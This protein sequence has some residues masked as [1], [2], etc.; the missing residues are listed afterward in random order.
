MTFA[1]KGSTLELRNDLVI[2][3]KVFAVNETYRYDAGSS[4]WR[5][6]T[7]GNAYT[8]VAPTW[9]QDEWT[10][11]GSVPKG[12]ARAKVRM[13]YT[14][15]GANAFRREYQRSENDAWTTFHSQ[16]CHRR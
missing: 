12:N 9:T 5:T 14:Y 7:Q 11:E 1:R 13:V 2:A 10:F 6:A 3:H 4:Q 15:L 16:T 8:G